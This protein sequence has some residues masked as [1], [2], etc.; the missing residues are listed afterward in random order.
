[1]KSITAFVVRTISF[2]GKNAVTV[3]CL[4]LVLAGVST[5]YAATHF[6]LTT[7]INK[8]ISPNIDWRQREARFEKAFPQFELIVAVVDAPTPELVDAATNALVGKLQEQQ[9]LFQ[10]PKGGPF[11]A[12]NG[13]LF[14][15]VK[16]LEPQMK[17]L[18]QA[19]RL[20]QVLAG[21]PSLRGVIQA[22]QFGL[23]GVQGGQITLDNMQ[24]PM[25]LGADALG[26]VNAG[27]P[28]AFSWHEMV[29]GHAATSSER[30][31]FLEIRATLDY[32]ELEPGHRASEAIRKAATDL[33]FAGKYQARLRLTGPVPMADEEFSTVRENAGVNATVTIIIVLI[34]LWLA[35]RWDSPSPPRSAC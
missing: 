32:S 23:L 35:L 20:V 27:Q 5:W 10:Q 4:S 6:A 26:K 21:D 11:F 2:C 33:D 7:D 14:E 9:S 15:D 24:W 29:E 8:L 31:R 22:L 17:A 28:A 30:L 16:D 1:M 13:L 12:Q 34:I 3:I 19:Q 25:N 18:T